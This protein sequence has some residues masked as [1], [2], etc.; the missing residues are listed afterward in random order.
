VEKS[1]TGQSSPASFSRL[2]TIPAVW[3]KG[4]LNRILIDRQNRM[5]ASEKTAGR[6]G[7]PPRGARQIMSVS[8]Q[9][10]SDPRSHSEAVS[11]D[12]FVVR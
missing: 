12:Q 1:G 8:T 11:L 6:P 5:A 2:A 7:R 4:S 10:S 9:I 3:R